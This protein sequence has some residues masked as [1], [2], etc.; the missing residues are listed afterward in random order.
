MK[1]KGNRKHT[2]KNGLELI[3]IEENQ[4]EKVK[5]LEST[6][7]ES[8]FQPQKVSSNSQRINMLEYIDLEDSRDDL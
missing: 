2:K 3:E 1:G 4:D 8:N 7:I 5:Y 6:L